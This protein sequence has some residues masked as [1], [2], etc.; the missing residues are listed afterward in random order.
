MLVAFVLSLFSSHFI[1]DTA[2]LRRA[3]LH[4][5][6]IDQVKRSDSSSIIDQA[7]RLDSSSTPL[8][9][10]RSLSVHCLVI[11]QQKSTVK[12]LG[13]AVPSVSFNPRSASMPFSG[14]FSFTYG[15]NVDSSDVLAH[16]SGL[17]DSG[18]QL[19]LSQTSTDYAKQITTTSTYTTTTYQAFTSGFSFTATLAPLRDSVALSVSITQS[20]PT[21][22]ASP[23]SLSGMAASFI[24]TIPIGAY[25]DVSGLDIEQDRRGWGLFSWYHTRSRRHVLVRI[26]VLDPR[27]MGAPNGGEAVGSAKGIQKAAK[28]VP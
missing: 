22:N 23:P 26:W 8:L 14:S 17:T 13:L 2:D 21:D 27:A 24:A 9:L 15:L 12:N 20:V 19:N 10:R 28:P 18:Q 16:Y 7:K 6:I 1:V 3:G 4:F 11:D 5:A 25:I